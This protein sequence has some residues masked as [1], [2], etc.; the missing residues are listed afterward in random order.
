VRDCAS[1]GWPS[2]FYFLLDRF[3][4]ANCQTKTR[5]AFVNVNVN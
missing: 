1:R 3:V 4:Q 2:E 5:A